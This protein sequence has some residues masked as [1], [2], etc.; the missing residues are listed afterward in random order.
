MFKLNL[1]ESIPD[2]TD[3]APSNKRKYE[4]NTVVKGI[5]STNDYIYKRINYFS[6]TDNMLSFNADVNQNYGVGYPVKLPL[7]T[8]YLSSTNNCR[9]ICILH[10]DIEGTYI[11][12]VD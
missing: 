5:A 6:L 4:F 10:Y 8:Y 11:S 12:R 9:R 3:S 2:N 7:G 1:P